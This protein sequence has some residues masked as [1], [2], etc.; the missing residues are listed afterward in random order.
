MH[1]LQK[2]LAILFFQNYSYRSR[3]YVKRSIRMQRVKIFLYKKKI[4]VY[5][6]EKKERVPLKIL[7]KL[8]FLYR[9]RFTVDAINY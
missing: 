7:S 9:S 2:L 1:D 3:V 8:F 5:M 4:Y 6:Y